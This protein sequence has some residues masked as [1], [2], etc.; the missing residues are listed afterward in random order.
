MLDFSVT[1]G[2]R[3][4]MMLLNFCDAENKP[5]VKE[6]RLLSY[7]LHVS[8][9][10]GLRLVAGVVPAASSVPSGS[11]NP[12]GGLGQPVEQSHLLSQ[13]QRAEVRLLLAWTWL[14]SL[15]RWCWFGGLDHRVVRRLQRGAVLLRGCLQAEEEAIFRRKIVQQRLWISSRA[16]CFKGNVEDLKSSN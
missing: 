12:A 4:M 9:G 5:R 2:L 16:T 14:L 7:L 11:G 3:A 8:K 10:D 1:T 13:A 6:F 15:R